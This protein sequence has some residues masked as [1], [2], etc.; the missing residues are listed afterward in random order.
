[1]PSLVRSGART[2]AKMRGTKLD[3]R[4]ELDRQGI[5]SKA[6]FDRIERMPV[7]VLENICHVLAM[8]AGTYAGIILT[9]EGRFNSGLF[10]IAGATLSEIAAN[11][12]NLYKNNEKVEAIL[13]EHKDAGQIHESKIPRSKAY[14][15]ALAVGGTATVLTSLAS[16]WA[17]SKI[18]D[19]PDDHQKYSNAEY[20]LFFVNVLSVL[21]F[22]ALTRRIKGNDSL[23]HV[24][25]EL[26]LSLRN[27]DQR[28]KSY[29]LGLMPSRSD[30]LDFFAGGF[31][32]VVMGITFQILSQRKDIG[33]F[34][35]AGAAL[36]GFFTLKGM[37][38]MLAR[39]EG[40]ELDYWRKSK[41]PVKEEEE[42]E[43][44]R[45]NACT[46][47]SGLFSR[48]KNSMYRLLTKGECNCEAE[49]LSPGHRV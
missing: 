31:A 32:T 24:I 29:F 14:E 7:S 1:M 2:F 8:G 44:V 27:G 40:Q 48:A 18:A 36:V 41:T 3:L 9:Q 30:A 4:E 28:L 5:L 38:H 15:R 20:A 13:K 6:A 46:W 26:H 17:A 10:T 11:T 34:P 49:P 42:K 21:T 12:F 16:F 37:G 19:N 45:S 23:N 25:D 22:A 39:S 43:E 47:V 33:Y 35:A